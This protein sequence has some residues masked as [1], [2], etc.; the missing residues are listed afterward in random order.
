MSSMS[1]SGSQFIGWCMQHFSPPWMLHT[2]QGRPLNRGP[3]GGRGNK[4]ACCGEQSTG[5]ALRWVRMEMPQKKMHFSFPYFPRCCKL[6]LH[7]AYDL[8]LFIYFIL[9]AFHFQVIQKGKNPQ[10]SFQWLHTLSNIPVQLMKEHLLLR[11]GIFTSSRKPLG[12][13]L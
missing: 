2:T 9:Y 11:M 1:W 4:S 5:R 7:S 12:I 6:G 13:H 10:R 3:G 8:L